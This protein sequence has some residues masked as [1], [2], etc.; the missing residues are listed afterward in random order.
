MPRPCTHPTYGS[1]NH[2]SQNAGLQ[3]NK[4]ATK[5]GLN[6]YQQYKLGRGAGSGS[7]VRTA[8]SVTALL[9]ADRLL[10]HRHPHS[11]DTRTQRGMCLKLFP[12]GTREASHLRHPSRSPPKPERRRPCTQGCMSSHA[13]IQGSSTHVYNMLMAYLEGACSV[14]MRAEPA[15]ACVHTHSEDCYFPVALGGDCTTMFGKLLRRSSS[16]RMLYPGQASANSLECTL[17]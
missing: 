15:T 9:G 10:L 17:H 11:D 4:H 13:V 2:R 7:F 16:Y 8:L 6:M 5:D 3:L 14:R 1:F 12:A